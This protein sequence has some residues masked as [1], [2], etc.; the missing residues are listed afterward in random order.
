MTFLV[1]SVV[2]IVGVFVGFGLATLLNM[3]SH[4]WDNE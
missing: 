1:L 2:F 3:A 4:N